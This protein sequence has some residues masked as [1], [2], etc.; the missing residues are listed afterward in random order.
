MGKTYDVND[1]TSKKICLDCKESKTVE[2]FSI[3]RKVFLRSRCKLCS[4][5]HNSI[6]NK[7]TFLKHLL[8][9]SKVRSKF[10]G[11][12]GRAE[13]SINTLTIESIE[14]IVKNQKNK[15]YYSGIEMNFKSH[16]EWMASLERLDR[17]KGY[18]EENTVLCC[19]EFNSQGQM[20]LDKINQINILSDKNVDLKELKKKMDE[21]SEPPKDK[22][23]PEGFWT[24]MKIDDQEYIYCVTCGFYKEKELFAKSIRSGCVDCRKK[25]NIEVSNKLR[26]FLQNM[27]S[28]MKQAQK[29]KEDKGR[30]M[31]SQEITVKD[32]LNKIWDQKGRCAYSN[33]PM[34]YVPNSDWKC[35]PER[36]DPTKGYVKDN[37]IFIC[38][39][40]NTSTKAHVTTNEIFG[41]SQWNKEKV[42]YLKSILNQ[43]DT[44]IIQELENDDER[45]FSISDEEIENSSSDMEKE[46]ICESILKYSK[47]DKKCINIAKYFKKGKHLC[48][49]H[50]NALKKRMKKNKAKINCEGIIKEYNCRKG[51]T[52]IYWAKYIQKDKY[53]CG[54]HVDKNI[55]K[56]IIKEESSESESEEIE[57][58]SKSEEEKESEVNKNMLGTK[59]QCKLSKHSINPLAR[60]NNFVKYFQKGKYLC[61]IH[62]DK[63]KNKI[64]L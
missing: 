40:F 10:R 57:I 21:A 15:C 32:L 56:E 17:E 60:C 9:K 6:T 62:I 44:E 29:K 31:E 37:I 48:G 63:N 34:N 47:S 18:T 1:P 11:E 5:K 3:H 52:C 19:Y 45:K 55:D 27:I 23:K 26:F 12:K 35:S 42:D 61:G 22:K 54:K 8:D 20:S 51:E 33:I 13:A 30:I 14:K 25:K 64:I 59:C 36:I 28:R 43:K 39:E 46:K 2:H 53:F 4:T 16:S 58:E 50:F 49:I 38:L 41:S 24:Q 7:Y